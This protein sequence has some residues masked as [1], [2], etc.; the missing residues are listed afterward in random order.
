MIILPA[1]D[2]IDGKPVRLYQG[3]YSRMTVVADD[4][5]AT[6]AGFAAAGAAWIHLV[7]L[8]GARTGSRKN[9]A[10]I[11][12]A[13]QISG[14]KAEVG[15]GIRTMEDIEFY[16]SGGISRVILGTAA[17]ENESL[18]KEAVAAFGDRIA[19]GIDARNGVV[20]TAGWLAETDLE[21]VPFAEHICRLGV[22]T[23]IA[24]DISRDGTMQG[25]NF[26]LYRQ[27]CGIRG[28]QV[29]ASGGMHSA[30]DIAVLSGIG[31]AGAVIGKA[32]YDGSIDLKEVLRDCGEQN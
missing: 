2:I 28:L 24:T 29:I 17:V 14:L 5:T 22:R 13:A 26:A 9:A 19:V 4:I 30:E 7:D 12:R 32:L 31:T 27:L 20:R 16:L 21:A 6:A 3:D 15:G 10:L 1:I 11:C 23:V 8:D 18:L 25:P